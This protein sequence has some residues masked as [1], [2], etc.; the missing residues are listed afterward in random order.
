M[1]ENMCV[2]CVCYILYH[3][4]ISYPRLFMKT[5]AC[6]EIETLQKL[7]GDRRARLSQAGEQEGD[8]MEARGGHRPHGGEHGDFG[9]Q[10]EALEQ[11]EDPLGP[12]GQEGA[13]VLAHD[14]P[15]SLGGELGD[16]LLGQLDGLAQGAAAHD[17][18]L[19]ARR[20]G[21][22]R[23]GL[24]VPRRLAQH[25][26]HKGHGVGLLHDLADGGPL[27]SGDQASHD[28]RSPSCDGVRDVGRLG[29]RFVVGR[30][31]L[32]DRLA[33]LQ[34]LLHPPHQVEGLLK[35][36]KG[37]LPLGVDQGVPE[38]LLALPR[39]GR[40][41]PA[42]GVRQASLVHVELGVALCCQTLQGGK[43]PDQEDRVGRAQ[44]LV[45]V[46][47]L[48]HARHQVP[49][50]VHLGLLDDL[51][52]HQGEVLDLAG[53]PRALLLVQP[54]ELLRNQL[55]VLEVLGETR[56]VH[57]DEVD[58]PASERLH[59]PG[60]DTADQPEVYEDQVAVRGVQDVPLVR[61]RVHQPR[62]QQ[63]RPAG[64]DGL[65]HE[66][67]LLGKLKLPE[68]LPLHPLH[69][70]HPLR[71]VL[72]EVPGDLDVGQESVLELKLLG[73]RGLLPVVQLVPHARRDLVRD[74]GQVGVAAPQGPEGHEAQ[75]QD[76]HV[77]KEAV[78]DLGPLHLDRHPLPLP[79]HPL[80]DLPQG[81]RR[82]G[83]PGQLL[84]QVVLSLAL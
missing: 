42:D 55:H 22:D 74:R 16:G 38:L 35:V 45:V 72:H 29:V 54:H 75:P 56:P 43:G 21:G 63:H 37:E 67:Q 49:E 83:L 34:L 81:R 60:V 13:R 36:L 8:H 30:L 61:V 10:E 9:H 69:R 57:R 50:I 17:P 6:C 70:Q 7:V 40:Q 11:Q 2:L 79:R 46:R 25:L 51:A 48:L 44:E 66:V 78:Q 52:D 80:V 1:Y 26:V 32:R 84:E 3:I 15:E 39:G 27:G 33:L 31:A 65:G 82:D 73:V 53:L 41:A 23:L 20:Q 28:L 62:L 71:G 18:L 77:K 64:L 59:Q 68:L 4:K 24:H 58:H 19:Q 5:K 76:V 12:R 47:H 14:A